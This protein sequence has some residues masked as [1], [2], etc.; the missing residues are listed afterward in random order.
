MK[1]SHV[2]GNTFQKTFRSQVGKILS[3][4]NDIF[5]PDMWRGAFFP[6]VPGVRA[7]EYK[8]L[9]TNKSVSVHLQCT[10]QV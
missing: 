2:V 1:E 8:A 4:Q 6:A 10:G 7:Y 5:A 9:N 3:G